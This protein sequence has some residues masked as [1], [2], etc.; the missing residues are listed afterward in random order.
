[1]WSR[2]PSWRLSIHMYMYNILYTYTHIYTHTPDIHYILINIFMRFLIYRAPVCIHSASMSQKW[3]DSFRYFMFSERDHESATQ[4][5]PRFT[6]INGPQSDDF[7]PPGQK[8]LPNSGYRHLKTTATAWQMFKY[9]FARRNCYPSCYSSEV[10]ILL[11]CEEVG[12]PFC[13][14][15]GGMGWV[16]N[17]VTVGPHSTWWILWLTRYDSWGDRSSKQPMI[18]PGGTMKKNSK[19]S[20]PAT[21]MMSQQAG[22]HTGGFP[23]GKSLTLWVI[24]C[25]NGKS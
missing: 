1:M 12:T 21:A 17:C 13:E 18:S 5:K 4:T 10:T 23:P 7:K 19:V 25:A 24:K 6:S 16:V 20:A 3:G 11:F 15:T 8:M 2:G 14:Q 9:G 22:W